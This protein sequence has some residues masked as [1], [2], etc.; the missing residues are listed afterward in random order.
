[1]LKKKEKRQKRHLTRSPISVQSAGPAVAS[2]RPAA[3][4]AMAAERRVGRLELCRG[5]Q[6]GRERGREGERERGWRDVLHAVLSLLNTDTQLENTGQ[7]E[8]VQECGVYSKRRVLMLHCKKYHFWHETGCV[9]LLF[10]LSTEISCQVGSDAC[11][12][13]HFTD[14]FH[15]LLLYSSSLLYFGGDILLFTPLSLSDNCN[16]YKFSCITEILL[17]KFSNWY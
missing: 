12:Q 2:S 4:A 13:V 9:D 1:M 15:L 14:Y 10:I 6:R 17:K 5:R 16:K 11:N 3:S 8:R 7:E